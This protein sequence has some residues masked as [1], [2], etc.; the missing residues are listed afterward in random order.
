M[1]ML[2]NYNFNEITNKSLIALAMQP[3]IWGDTFGEVIGSFYGKMEF[4]VRGIGEI[5]KKTVEGTVSVFLSGFVSLVVMYEWYVP[6]GVLEFGV[7]PYGGRQVKV[8]TKVI[9]KCTKSDTSDHIPP[10]PDS[11]LLH[12]LHLHDSRGRRLPQ[13]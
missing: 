9:L 4:S 13:H 7:A 3:L 5:N 1:S 8:V 6:E 2:I 10:F 12:C 11:F